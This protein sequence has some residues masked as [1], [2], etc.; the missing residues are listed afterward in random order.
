MKIGYLTKRA[1]DYGIATCGLVAGGPVML[2]IAA[3][4]RLDSPGGALFVQERLGRDGKPFRLLKF[5][6]MRAAPIRYNSD[7]STKVDPSDDRVTRVGRYLRGALDE[8]PQLINVL[9]GEM[10][11]I[12]PRPDLV[13]QRA[14]YAPGEERKLAML[15]GITGLAVVMGRTDLPWKQR[16]GLDVMYVQ[17]WSLALDVKIGIQTLLMP[18]GLRVLELDPA[19]A[20]RSESPSG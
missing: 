8:L 5:R 10:S 6:T 15:P 3:A 19:S 4:I 17:R 20:R 9:R 7:G 18:L 2:G 1:L 11:L 12:G 14:L 16:I 13:G